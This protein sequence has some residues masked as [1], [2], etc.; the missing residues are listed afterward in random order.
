MKLSNGFQ[1]HSARLLV[2]LAAMPV[3]ISSHR[4]RKNYFSIQTTG[5]G[6]RNRP[7]LVA[8]SEGF[9]TSGVAS[10]L[11]VSIKSNDAEASPTIINLAEDLI[12]ILAFSE[13]VW[14]ICAPLCL[15]QF[16]GLR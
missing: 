2:N 7:S 14:P 8:G 6:N 13:N 15:C 10:P 1:N 5:I 12:S 4:L 11:S 16:V 3:I 9:A